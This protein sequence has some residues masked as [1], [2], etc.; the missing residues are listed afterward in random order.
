MIAFLQACRRKAA[1]AVRE[2]WYG[3]KRDVLPYPLAFIGKY[4]MK[5][6]LNTCKIEIS[7]L[8]HLSQPASGKCILMLWHNRIAVMC[9]FFERY[10][11]KRHYAAFL[12][13]SRDGEPIARVI[14]KYPNSGCI[15]VAHNLRHQALREAIG[16]LNATDGILL[17]TPDGPK[18]PPYKIKPGIL[19]AAK[20]A[21]APIIALSWE[22][23]KYWEL[24]TWDKFRLPKPF[25]HIKICLSH[26]IYLDPALDAHSALQG[27]EKVMHGLSNPS[28]IR[29]PL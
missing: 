2:V 4:G 17:I 15:R 20:E 3:F 28:E 24:K 13:K 18:G 9:E 8:H 23:S 16:Y 10:L 29:P 6:L 14:G 12:S 11:P 19:L 22:A 5:L 1:W 21:Q 26:P 7:G 25:S 27:L